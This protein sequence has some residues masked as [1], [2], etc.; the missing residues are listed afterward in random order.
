[1]TKIINK[2]PHELRI[3]DRNGNYLTLPAS[4]N[5]IR[6]KLSTISDTRQIGGMAYAVTKEQP[7]LRAIGR[8]IVE[9]NKIFENEDNDCHVV[10]SR[11][12][13]SSLPLSYKYL[14]RVLAPGTLIRVNGEPTGAIGFHVRLF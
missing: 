3:R 12:A 10:V 13:Q 6:V 14:K 8:L 7:T 5:P 9:L 1:M 2:V 11:L 4:N